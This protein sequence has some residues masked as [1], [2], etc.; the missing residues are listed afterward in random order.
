MNLIVGYGYAEIEGRVV[1]GVAASKLIPYQASIRV[2]ARDYLKFGDGHR[3]GGV[4]VNSKAVVTA[5][6][7]LMYDNIVL[8]T[9]QIYIVL[10]SLNR[11]EFTKETLIRYIKNIIVHPDYKRSQRFA[12]DIGLVI[13]RT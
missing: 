8:K 7:C 12:D 6:H 10:G 4:L 13:V 9:Y 3:C 1:N 11:Y 5:A 2:T